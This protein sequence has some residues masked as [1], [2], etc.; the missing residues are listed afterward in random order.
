L[1]YVLVVRMKAQEGSEGRALEVMRE[2]AEAS[3]QEPGCEAYVPCQDPD[4]PRSFIF[5]E[6]YRDK[7]AFEEHGATEHFQR[8]ALGELFPLMESRERSFYETVD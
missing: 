3:R 8:L 6:R 7:A 2:L 1:S 4:D 5:F